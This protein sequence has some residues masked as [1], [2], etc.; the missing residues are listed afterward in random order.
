LGVHLTSSTSMYALS[1]GISANSKYI[2]TY[3]I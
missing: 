3:R 2:D 1:Y